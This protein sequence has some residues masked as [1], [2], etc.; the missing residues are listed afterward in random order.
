HYEPE[1]D[2][3][4]GTLQ[5]ESVAN[6]PEASRRRGLCGQG[7]MMAANTSFLCYTIKTLVRVIHRSKGARALIKIIHTPAEG[8]PQDMCLCA[9]EPELLALVTS[10]GDLVVLRLSLSSDKGGGGTLQGG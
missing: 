1:K 3:S 4:F 8:E 7:A 9:Q 6:L 5:C 2:G 10:E